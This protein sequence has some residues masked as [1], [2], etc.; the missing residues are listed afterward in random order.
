M[1]YHSSISPDKKLRVA[2]LAEYPFEEND[3]LRGGVM[4]ANY[5]LIH[6]LGKLD[7]IELYVLMPSVKT[8]K[9][10]TRHEGDVTVIFFPLKNRGYGA[11]LR[12]PGIRRSFRSILDRIQPDLLHAQAAPAYILAATEGKAPSVVTIHGL[13]RNEFPVLK[14]HQSLRER[15][16]LKTVTRIQEECFRKIKNL[17]A[18]TG[19][20]EDLVK[21]YS[22]DVCTYRINNTI[23]EKFF[24]LQNCD[25][26]PM[27][28]FIGWIN[29]RKG[30][31]V[32]LE[33]FCRVSRSLPDAQLRLVGQDD[34]DRDYGAALKV[35]HQSLITSGN[36]Q[37]IGSISQEKLYEEMSRCSFLC[38]PSLA[39]SAPMVIAQ[40]MA[41]GKPVVATRVGGVSEMV[42]DGVTGFLCDPGN[43]DQLADA[44]LAL[45]KDPELRRKMGQKANQLAE[46]RYRASAVAQSTMEAYGRILGRR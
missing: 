1:T 40:A 20:I 29:N 19:E 14:H 26:K 11:L 4:Q 23:D 24:S 21:K 43:S 10:V 33:A 25:S 9:V 35:K 18:I 6:A 41:A 39:E 30:V 7:G 28:L 42:E 8:D 15:L 45:L 34:V 31:H 2:M 13:F 46:K 12:Y 44:L 36:V 37:F 3:L 22:P 5:R 38:L 32:L 17:I 16:V 27:V